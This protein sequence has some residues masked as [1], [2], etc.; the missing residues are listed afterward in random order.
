MLKR[1]HLQMANSISIN[2]KWWC[3]EASRYAWHTL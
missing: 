1:K 2:V 3:M